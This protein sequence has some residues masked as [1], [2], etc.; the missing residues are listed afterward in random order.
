MLWIAEKPPGAAI[1]AHT[2]RTTAPDSESYEA[3]PGKLDPRDVVAAL[4]QALPQDWQL[5]NTSG[6]CAHFFAHM[7][8]R[9]QSQ[10]LNIREFG[11]TG[12]GTSFALGVATARPDEVVA[13]LDEDGSLL[14]HI[15]ELENILRHRIKVLLIVMNDGAHGAEL[16][17]LRSEKMSV[18]GSVFGYCDFAAIA[19]GFGLNGHRIEDL[20]KIPSL[21]QSFEQSSTATLWYFHVSDKVIS[22]VLRKPH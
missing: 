9:P 2:I 7:P 18:E 1:E 4:E 15:Q 14:M 20:S 19:Q 5:V 13:L 16:H 10:F 6:H 17:K 11:A 12:N 22:P 3:E 21:V 8:S